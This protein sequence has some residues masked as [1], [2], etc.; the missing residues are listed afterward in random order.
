MPGSSLRYWIGLSSILLFV[1]LGFVLFSRGVGGQTD[2]PFVSGAQASEWAMEG[3]NPARTR[4]IDA[5][6]ALPISNQRELNVDDDQ[7]IGSPVAVA[8]N[9]LLVEADGS[10]RAIDLRTG[11]ERWTFAGYGRYISPAVVGDTVYI[12]SEA[13][14]EG[15]VFAIDL[16]TGK[17][18]WAFKPRRISS[19]ATGFWG[20]HITS[21]VIVDGVVFV[22]AGEEL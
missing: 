6:L 19:P 2:T 4:A 1:V 5:D 15:E 22:G 8:Q 16:G 7:G 12:R 11:Q 3:Y 14:N 17:Q 20:G 18:R 13:N 21:P 10:L 9:T